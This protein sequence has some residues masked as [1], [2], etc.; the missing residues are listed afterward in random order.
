M[1]LS[2]PTNTLA[3]RSNGKVSLCLRLS[4]V[5][6][7]IGG[8]FA[9]VYVL[10]A[11][12]SFVPLIPHA[13]TAISQPIYLGFA[14]PGARIPHTVSITLDLVTLLFDLAIGI[15][16]APSLG[17]AGQWSCSQQNEENECRVWNGI[18]AAQGASAIILLFVA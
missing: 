8:L 12:G 6:L 16:F 18:Y 7:C 10:T 9:S 14:Y 2:K 3:A 11:G 1:Q 17:L 13:F 15:L 5:L 4:S